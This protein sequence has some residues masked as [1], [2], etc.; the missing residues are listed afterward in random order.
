M[1]E[2]IANALSPAQNVIVNITSDDKEKTALA[3]V[4]DDELSKAI[5]KQGIN[6]KLA[7][8]LTK[9]RI[10]IKTMTQIQEEGNQ[11]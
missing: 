3:I 2:Y 5:G 9:Y 8:R 7:S 10:E 11:E 4:P 6:I 1:S